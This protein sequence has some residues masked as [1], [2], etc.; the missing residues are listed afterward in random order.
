MGKERERKKKEQ[1][2]R[3]TREVYSGGGRET[4]SSVYIRKSRYL[5]TLNQ[6][7]FIKEYSLEAWSLEIILL[8]RMTST[9]MVSAFP[10]IIL[11]IWY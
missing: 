11:V 2:I 6:Y 5:C 3:L 1:L 10:K 9:I 7:S 4:D 8:V